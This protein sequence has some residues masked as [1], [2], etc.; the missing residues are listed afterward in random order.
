M[1]TTVRVYKSQLADARLK[2][3]WGRKHGR[4]RGRGKKA[5]RLT[6][7][8]TWNLEATYDDPKA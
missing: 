2:V 4:P 1:T 7:R 8:V 6:F 3:R 5:H